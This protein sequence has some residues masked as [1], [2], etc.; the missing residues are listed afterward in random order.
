MTTLTTLYKR[1]Q[2]VLSWERFFGY[3]SVEGSTK[4]TASQYAILAA[5]L[6]AVNESVRLCTYKTIRTTMTA[7]LIEN[8]LS[9]ERRSVSNQHYRQAAEGG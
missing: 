3:L 7:H 1:M 5:A 6:K 2:A 4:F 8:F 9:A